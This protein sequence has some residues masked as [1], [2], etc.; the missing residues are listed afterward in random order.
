[1]SYFIAEVS[2]NHS[3]DLSRALEF[4]D[5]AADV[6]CDAVK[7]QLFKIDKLFAPEILLKS[8][9]HRSRRNWELPLDFLPHLAERCTTR[10]IDFGCTPFYLDA[11]AELEPY[12]NFYK[13]ASYE[14]IWDDLH[15]LCAQTGKPVVISTGM[16][17]M[18]EITHAVDI[19][20]S[21][22]CSDPT[23][24]HCTSAYPTPYIEANLAAID[25][26]SQATKCKVG[27]SDHTVNEGVI[28]RAVNKWSAKVVEF[29]LDIEGDGEE[30]ESGH[31]W[32]PS[33][34]KRVIENVKDGCLSDGNGLKTPTSSE[35]P[36]REW[37]TEPKDGLRPLE[38]I[39]KSFEG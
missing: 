19:L 25:T 36:D 35:L 29:H 13:I 14:L 2:S 34:I 18:P 5:V 28:Y 33:Q 31:C 39:R 6:G 7:F 22:G 37:R 4:I 11:V 9:T 24:L 8:E 23:V 10:G 30:F 26:I 20:R 21:N 1:M 17:E 15:A 3:R 32:L 27:W 16:A 38:H 12:V